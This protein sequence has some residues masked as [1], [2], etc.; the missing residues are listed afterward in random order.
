[1]WAQ[2][3]EELFYRSGDR[4]MAVDITTEPTFTHGTPQLLFEGQYRFYGPR[5]MYDVTSDGQ[6]FLFIEPVEEV[7]A[8]PIHVVLNWHEE[9]QRLVPTG[10]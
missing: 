3:G 9:L 10:E 5:A 2:S 1:M 7:K 6:R 4:M 8:E